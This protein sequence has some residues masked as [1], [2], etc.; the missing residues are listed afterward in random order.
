MPPAKMNPAATLESLKEEYFDSEYTRLTP[1]LSLIVS[2]QNFASLIGLDSSDN[3]PK[4]KR[5]KSM[6]VVVK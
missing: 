1:R 3:K 6:S 5:S 2:T 4:H